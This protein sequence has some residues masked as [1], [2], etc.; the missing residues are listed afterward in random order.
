MTK[1]EKEGKKRE[2]K[3]GKVYNMAGKVT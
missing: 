3:I 1:K 2:Y